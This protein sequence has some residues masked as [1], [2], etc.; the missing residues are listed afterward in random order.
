ML[1]FRTRTLN[2]GALKCQRLSDSSSYHP[3][4]L[5]HLGPLAALAGTMGRER[6]G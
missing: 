4:L 1:K 3:E 6:R 2:K 5:A